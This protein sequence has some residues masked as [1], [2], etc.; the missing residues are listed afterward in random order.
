MK[1]CD[2]IIVGGGII[3]LSIAW[4]LAR[5][6]SLRIV[7]AEKGASVGEGSTGASSAVCRTR[8]TTDELLELARDGIAAY[9]DWRAYTGL[10]APS[11]E[12][13][14]DA[15][16]W[17]PGDDAGWADREAGR[18]RRFGVVA[19][20]LDSDETAAR[21][22]ALSNCTL[23]PDLET[24]EDH[25]CNHASR[26]LFEVEGGYVDPVA[27]AQDLVAACRSRGVDVRFRTRVTGIGVGGGCIRNVTFDSG[28]QLAA[29]VVINAA[30]PWCNELVGLA[31][32]ALPWTLEPTRIQIVYRD[33]PPELEGHIP[34]T[35][36]FAGGIY[37][38][39]QNRGQQLVIGSVLPEDE[40][41]GV[42]D[43]DDFQVETDQDFEVVKLHVLHHRL[44][45]L[46]YHGRVRGYCGL[47]TINRQDV[48]PVVG[49]T[50][51]EGFWLANGFSGHGFKLA[52]VIGA[53]LARQLTG[54]QRDFDTDIRPDLFAVDRQPIELES[55]S[56]LA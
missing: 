55:R 4:Q 44:P 16:L 33:R 7:V 48:H 1:T 42:A 39:T 17:M 34:I 6:S 50:E 56:V 15:V 52:P 54:E 10:T 25:D 46:P 40:E 27:A 32:L 51:V 9:R 45:A 36:D 53:M 18:L 28:E 47:Y 31:G 37:F 24:G 5:R 3:G 20:V 43:P 21:F 30:G 38:R 26:N 14:N 19:E 8:Y 49:P 23:A 12:F 11:A 22:P 41:E 35:A 13:H 2:V 29:P